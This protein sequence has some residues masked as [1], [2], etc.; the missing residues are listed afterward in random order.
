MLLDSQCFFL[1]DDKIAGIPLFREAF[2]AGIVLSA[3]ILLMLWKQAHQSKTAAWIV[4]FGVVLPVMSAILANLNYGQPLLY[5]LL[6]ER[7]SFTYLLFFPAY[8]LMVKTKPTQDQIERFM[9]VSGLA[10][11]FV[12]FLYYF[13][14]IPQ[15]A[16]VGFTVDEKTMSP[17]DNLLRPDRYRIGAN[18][19]QICA[20]MLM[21]SIKRHLTVVK[22]GI[23]G[24]FALYLW[25]VLQTRTTMIIWALAAC[26]VFRSKP[27]PLFQMAGLIV[28]ALALVFVIMPSAI[29][30][31]YDKF[32]ALLGEA[33]DGSSVR[34][35]TIALTLRDVARNHFV[36]LGALSLQWQ[37]GFSALYN[38]WFYL[39]DVGIVGVYYR[40]GFFTPLIA[41]TYYL[42]FI[43][44]MR[45]C[46][47]KNDMLAAFQL[48]FWFS[49]F[50]MVLANSIMYGGEISGL[51]A[52]AFLYAS[53]ARA[54][55]E[56]RIENP[57][58]DPISYRHY[59]PQ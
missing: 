8:F 24:L 14:I 16:N 25:L 40:F 15:T 35:T 31:Q 36:G 1:T 43:R 28:V 44:I 58:H 7:R 21:Y 32:N 42:G 23:L 19:V 22:V 13:K 47:N 33:T 59:K 26:W 54:T 11:V 57:R 49:L 17:D 45:N 34:D 51:A 27:R 48:D 39:S 41:L 5:G 30:D 20:F 18:Y 10:C 12:G 56:S 2:L 29:T 46:K 3:L 38:D 4:L 6:E 53:K 9:L 37:G 50:N 52:A 55:S